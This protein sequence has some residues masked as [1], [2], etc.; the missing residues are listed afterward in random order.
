MLP[1]YTLLN[2]I[3]PKLQGLGEILHYQRGFHSIT[4]SHP[5][6]EYLGGSGTSLSVKMKCF[7]PEKVTKLMKSLPLPLTRSPNFQRFLSA[8]A[9]FLEFSYQTRHSCH[10]IYNY[11]SKVK[12]F[13]SSFQLKPST[14]SWI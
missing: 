8:P 13:F 6:S 7:H 10:N 2:G 5:H 4:A 14:S 1:L 11:S 12:R 3:L 9:S